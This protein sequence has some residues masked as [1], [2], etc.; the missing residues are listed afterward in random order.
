VRER[1]EESVLKSLK[2]ALDL[3]EIIGE[4]GSMGI[5]QLSAR[6]GFPPATVHRIV[7]ALVERGYLRQNRNTRNYSLSTRFLEFAD[8]VQQRFDLVPIARPHLERLSMNTGESVNLCVLDGPVVVYIDHV[9]SQKHILRT[10]TRL[11]ARVPL[12]ATGVGKVYLSRMGAEELDSYLGNVKLERY[13]KKTI[14]DKNGL[15]EELERIR[16]RGYAV[17]DQEKEDGVRCVAAPVFDH[18]GSIAAAISISGAAQWITHERIRSLARM[19]MDCAG[20]ISAELGY[21]Y[22]KK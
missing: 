20:R 2:K 7:A 22:G 14:M 12:Y 8:S 5:R 19:V 10:F 16:E 3:I 13:T 6:T 9:H 1:D 4:S 17:D 18:S 15:L 11:G 21:R